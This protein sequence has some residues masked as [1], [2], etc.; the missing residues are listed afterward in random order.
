MNNFTRLFDIPYYQHA[1]YKVSKAVGDKT[2][3]KWEHYSSRQFIDIINEVSLG[4]LALGVQK[5]DKIA[6]ISTNNRAEWNIMD[7]GMMQIGAINVPVYPT[8]APKDYE[9]IFNEAEVKYCFVSDAA[10]LKKVETAQPNIPSLQNSISPP[11][12]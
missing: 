8:I 5:G 11:L 9:Y 7:L 4:L 12:R 3:G 6:L 2:S 1:T 10:L